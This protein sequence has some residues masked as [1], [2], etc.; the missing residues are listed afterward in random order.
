MWKDRVEFPELKRKVVEL[1]EKHNA[2]EILIEDKASG[3]SLIQEM[4]RETRLPIK[5]I[6]VEQD[7]IARVHA[8]TP[9]IEAGR[10]FL[11]KEKNWLKD[12]TDECEEFPNGEYDDVVDSVSQFLLNVKTANAG[13][14]KGMKHVKEA[15]WQMETEDEKE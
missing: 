14:Y 9:L 7:K 11:P 8:V 1:S 4:Q 15:R 12:F 3:Q 5:P 2:N 10:V 13:D 6:K